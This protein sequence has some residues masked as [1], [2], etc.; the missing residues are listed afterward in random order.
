MPRGKLRPTLDEVK[1]LLAADRDVLRP[2]VQA[3]L[4]EL[5]EAEM[6]AALGAEKGER[7]PARLGHRSGYYG[8]TLVTRVGK[9]E[10]CVPQDREGRFSTEL[11]EALPAL[12]E[13]VGGG[14]GRDVRAR[15]VDAEGQ[16]DHRGALRPQLL[17]RGD[18]RDQRQARR[19]AGAV[20]PPAVGRGLPVPDRG[21]TLRAGARGRRD[22]QPGG[23][24]G[25]RHRLGRPAQ[26]PRGR[27]R[28][29]REPLEL[30]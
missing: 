9:L 27:A 25:D 20:R 28:Q 3:V 26:H 6:T 12:G 22:P 21:R 18:Q 15:R 13:G 11:F 17:G 19:G 7:T 14:A 10:L 16:G 8:R 5:L 2:L 24:A 23:A 29:P 4:Q 1:A 30:A